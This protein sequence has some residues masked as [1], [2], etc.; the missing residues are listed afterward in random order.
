MPKIPIKKPPSFT[1][2]DLFRV[3]QYTLDHKRLIIQALGL[4]AALLALFLFLTISYQLQGSITFLPWFFN[5][6]GFIAFYL[7]TLVFAGPVTYLI[8]KEIETG[9]RSSIAEAFRKGFHYGVKLVIAPLGI[10]AFL[11]ASS[12]ALIICICLGMVPGAGTLLWS[13][14]ILPQF[15]LALFLMI[16]TIT[17]LVGTLLLPSVIINEGVSSGEAFLFLFRLMQKRFLTFWGYVFTS[18]F[19]DAVYFSLVTVIVLGALA[20]FFGVSTLILGSI[21]GEVVLSIPSF[22]YKIPSPLEVAI[23]FPASRPP[24]G[25]VYPVSGFLGGILLLIIYVAWLSYP[26]LYAFNSGVIMY[27]ALKHKIS[28]FPQQ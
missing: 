27:L 25:W 7:I 2:P 1:Y 8:L 17:L 28:T 21:P 16:G 5:L 18:I 10:L 20:V 3:V 6:L 24:E 22:F 15:I 11:L 4:V 9:R 13:L 26:L 19:L 12:I 14:L 23:S